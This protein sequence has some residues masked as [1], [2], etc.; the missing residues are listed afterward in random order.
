MKNDTIAAIAMSVIALI[1]GGF[2]LQSF[3]AGSEANIPGG[4]MVD[5]GRSGWL[6]KI[7]FLFMVSASC[8]LGAIQ[9]LASKLRTIFRL[10]QS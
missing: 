9:V 10:N 5:V 6:I 2:F 1:S 8:V 3:L 4:G 7:S